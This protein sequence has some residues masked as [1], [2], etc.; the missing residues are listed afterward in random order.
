LRRHF[1]EVRKLTYF[2]EVLIGGVSN[3]DVPLLERCQL[4]IFAE[5]LGGELELVVIAC[6]Y[7]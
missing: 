1:N 3:F 5:P 7:V 6:L 2:C 4:S